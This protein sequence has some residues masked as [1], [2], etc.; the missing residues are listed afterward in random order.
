MLQANAALQL[1]DILAAYNL[2]NMTTV[3]TNQYNVWQA[4]NGNDF[5]IDVRVRI[6]ANQ[7]VLYRWV[8][9]CTVGNRLVICAVLGG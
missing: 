8:A 1:S 2:R 5:T 9:V 4:G 3:L 7:V 6:P